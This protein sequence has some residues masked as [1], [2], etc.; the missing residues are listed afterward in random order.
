MHCPRG[1]CDINYTESTRN[2]DNMLD[3]FQKD[4]NY[5]VSLIKN[6]TGKLIAEL[7][8]PSSPICMDKKCLF[9]MGTSQQ[10]YSLEERIE[11]NTII[12][13][14]VVNFYS[15]P[16]CKNMKR[17][18]DFK[19]NEIGK[20][21]FIEC[22]SRAGCQ[23]IVTQ[24]C[25]A[26]LYIIK[27]T[28]P[29]TV[30]KILNSEYIDDLN[31]CSAGCNTDICT[32]KNYNKINYLGLDPYTNN[33]LINW[34]INNRMMELNIPNIINME[35]GFVCGNNGYCL[36]EHCDIG[37]LRHLQE[38]PDYLDHS[39]RPSPTATADDKIAISKDVVKGIIMQL[40]AT[41]HALKEFDFSHGN[42]C[43]RTLLLK[44]D[45]CS[46]MY[47]GVHVEC[48]LTI[49]LCDFHQ[50][51]ITVNNNRLYNKSVVADE[52]I[53]RRSYKPILEST[54][55]TKFEF[56]NKGVIIN[57]EKVSIYRLKN[58]SGYYEESIVFMY[59]KHLGLPLY[60]TSF[61]AYCYMISLMSDRSF[62]TTVMNDESMYS[63]WRNMWLPDEFSKVQEMVRKLHDIPDPVTKVELVIKYL[64]GYG[65]RCDMIDH[66]WNMIKTW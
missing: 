11:G 22:G 16:Q 31:R 25:L 19:T 62:Y 52:S 59:I 3:S 64:A 51:G 53:S 36:Y 57:P 15:C 54:Q 28:P 27:E 14:N 17:L 5:I 65:L 6:N 21:F 60:Q 58:P 48:P 38:Y 39:C 32:I 37:R 43:S 47:D 20:P 2:V 55:I 35:I 26:K 34:V 44:S 45:P 29:K 50:S 56:D 18:L 8:T 66:G 42:P 12:N 30:A 46:Y 10:V 9:S 4:R 33:V 23:L 40:F 24:E 49:K 13:E 7:W 1:V 61:D 41:L 63:M